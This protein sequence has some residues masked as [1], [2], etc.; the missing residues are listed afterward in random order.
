MSNIPKNFTTNKCLKV[1]D[2]ITLISCK[3]LLNL[4]ENCTSVREHP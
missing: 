3:A 2:S 1:S 4:V